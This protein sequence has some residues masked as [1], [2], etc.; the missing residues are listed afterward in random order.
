M[1]GLSVELQTWKTEPDSDSSI[2]PPPPQAQAHHY[3]SFSLN[4]PSSA[5]MISME[6]P[7]MGHIG[8]HHPPPHH[9]QQMS[10][11]Y[12]G[13]SDKKKRECTLVFVLEHG[14]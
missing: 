13:S 5:E 11:N 14:L 7:P 12:D 8:Q 10:P 1:T 3:Q 9:Q 2:P 4:S 6:M